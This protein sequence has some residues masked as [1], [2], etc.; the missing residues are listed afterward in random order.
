M[1]RHLQPPDFP[2]L[3]VSLPTNTHD[4]LDAHMVL[5]GHISRVRDIAFHLDNREVPRWRKAGLGKSSYGATVHCRWNVGVCPHLSRY[6]RQHDV[7]QIC[8]L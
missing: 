6:A 4:M 8:P 7:L 1:L 2:V 5:Q 3:L